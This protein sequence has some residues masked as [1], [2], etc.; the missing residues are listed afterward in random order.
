MLSGVGNYSTVWFTLP[1]SGDWQ[2]KL[3]VRFFPDF[4]YVDVKLL[5]RSA[6][7][8]QRLLVPCLIESSNKQIIK[9][10]DLKPES[11]HI[12]DNLISVY[13]TGPYWTNA[14]QSDYKVVCTIQC[15]RSSGKQRTMSK[16]I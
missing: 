15:D 13:T 10:I 9:S 1:M 11:M 7:Q 12:D 5:R 4:I 3:D 2:W 8:L 6:N 14:M 16:Y